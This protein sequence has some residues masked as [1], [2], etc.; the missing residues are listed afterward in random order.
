MNRKFASLANRV[1]ALFSFAL[2][3]CS[4]RVP[5]AHASRDGFSFPPPMEVKGTKYGLFSKVVHYPVRYCIMV[6][7][8][9]HHSGDRNAKQLFCILNL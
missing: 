7:R 3:E 2:P 4:I 1:I 8:V 6:A 9:L 5:A